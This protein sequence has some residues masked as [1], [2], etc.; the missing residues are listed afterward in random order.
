MSRTVE[1]S[2]AIL[3]NFEDF[4]LKELLSDHAQQVWSLDAI[5]A[6]MAQCGDLHLAYPT[7][8]VAG[9]KGK[10]STCAFIA[11]ALTASG[12]RTGLYTSPPLGDFRESIQIDGQW[13]SREALASLIEE[14]FEVARSIPNLSRFEYE[15]GL[16]FLYFA[17]EGVDFAVIEVGM[18]GRLDATN[19]VQPLVAVITPISL[20]HQAFLGD[21]LAQIAAE[22]AG[23]IKGGIPIVVAEQPPE[24][25]AVI[26][27]RATAL[28][29]PLYRSGTDY[30]VGFLSGDL[31]GS[32]ICFDWAGQ[33]QELCIRLPGIFQAENAGA[34]LMTLALLAPTRS[35]IT[36]ES[37]QQGLA[38]TVWPGRLEVI[39]RHPLIL[40]DG[41][42]TPHAV[43][44]L[45]E[46]LRALV[47]P[48]ISS[49]TI[50]F[51][52][53]RDKDHR[54]MLAALL[55]LAD[56]LILTGISSDRAASP[57]ILY[58]S[59]VDLL[60]L[61]HIDD[62]YGKISEIRVVADP[63]EALLQAH[64]L[65]PP[66]GAILITGSLAIVG[67]CHPRADH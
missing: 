12:P 35:A 37:I 58:Q 65:T 3:A 31:G 44:R 34:A 51:G 30:R 26:E 9:T 54:A 22:K 60:R 32:R 66:S 17:R 25:L 8:H 41:A 33:S 6:F 42:H 40:L 1:E 19:I 29:C 16:A 23:I 46:S 21:T 39:S 20:E 15:T 52:C 36:P 56:Q 48:E 43:N 11:A 47:L 50:I 5:T 7:I 62:S 55:P 2:L 59:A 63:Q 28:S 38:A 64:Q 49:L 4:H 13:I 18:G 10:G 57:F 14:T 27:A 45:V 61:K 67:A 53:M 24:A